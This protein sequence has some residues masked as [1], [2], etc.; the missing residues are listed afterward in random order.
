MHEY[1]LEIEKI[2]ETIQKNN[3][4]KICLQLPDG[5]KPLAKEITDTIQEKTKASVIIWAG[6]NF[7]ACDLPL[8]VKK[9]G[10]D[11]LV[12]FGHSQWV[13]DRE[14]VR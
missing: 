10:V 4:R 11:L 6:S 3:F 2:I 1:D 12:P 9:L 8:E 13:Y 5:L 14:I 7:G